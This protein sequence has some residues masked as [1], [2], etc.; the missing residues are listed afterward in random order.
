MKWKVKTVTVLLIE[1]FKLKKKFFYLPFCYEFLFVNFYWP[2][3]FIGHPQWLVDYSPSAGNTSQSWVPMTQ[4]WTS[5]VGK[6]W[7]CHSE[8]VGSWSWHQSWNKDCE[9]SSI[10]KD[11]NYILVTAP[12][13]EIKIVNK[14]V[15]ERIRTRTIID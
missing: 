9:Q 5:G 11:K 15:F 4:A 6:T 13:F 10:W 8:W 12:K 3:T 1:N 14:V 7:S 2:L